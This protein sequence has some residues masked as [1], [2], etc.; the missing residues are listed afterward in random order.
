MEDQLSSVFLSRLSTEELFA[1]H[2]KRWS[3]RWKPSMRIETEIIYENDISSE[4]TVMDIFAQ[5]AVGLLY[6]IT[7]TPS[8]LGLDIYTARV[9]TQ[10]DKAVDSFYVSL[11]GDKIQENDLLEEIRLTLE[12]QLG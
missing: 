2:Q 10:A 12:D 4:N 11:N 3:R 8:N 7:R 6:K 9:S 5:D 1:R